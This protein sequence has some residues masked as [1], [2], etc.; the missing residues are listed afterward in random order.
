MAAPSPSTSLAGGSYNSQ[1]FH[2]ADEVQEHSS[3][4][5]AP[6]AAHCS[7]DWSAHHWSC[8][9]HSLLPGCVD[10]LHREQA[11]WPAQPET[12]LVEV[13]R[14]RREGVGRNQAAPPNCLSTGPGI[15]QGLGGTE[16][17][18]R[19]RCPP[20]PLGPH[21]VPSGR[22]PPSAPP[23]QLILDRGPIR[24]KSPSPKHL[25]WGLSVPHQDRGLEPPPRHREARSR[26]TLRA[27]TDEQTNPPIEALI[28]AQ[29]V[30]RL[31]TTFP[32]FPS[33]RFLLR[34]L[35]ALVALLAVDRA[36]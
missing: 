20:R 16:G 4:F 14:G 27:D 18:R 32:R 25:A 26:S 11:D 5:S 1:G 2:R 29:A 22:N 7:R 17:R 35:S 13:D 10:G 9:A 21:D 28:P 31:A 6:A 19:H 33:V 12:Q 8:G 24:S 3:V 15:G 30:P 34:W 36:S 23:R